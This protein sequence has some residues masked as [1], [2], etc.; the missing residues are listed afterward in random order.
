MKI[1]REEVEKGL[2]WNVVYFP[3]DIT[4]VNNNN[5]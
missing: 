1:I 2:E 4:I 5:N 3:C